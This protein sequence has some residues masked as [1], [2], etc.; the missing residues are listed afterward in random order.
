MDGKQTQLCYLNIN[1]L[2]YAEEKGGKKNSFKE[3]Q[4]LPGYCGD[5]RE[6]EL[7]LPG[8]NF[9][10]YRLQTHAAQ[11]VSMGLKSSLETSQ[12]FHGS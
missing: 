1:T 8:D 10:I 6:L 3:E 5:G 7:L 2:K 9:I 4:F 11:R 12:S